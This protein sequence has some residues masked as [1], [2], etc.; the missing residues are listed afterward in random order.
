MTENLARS[1]G[2]AD[3]GVASR[4]WRRPVARNDPSVTLQDALLARGRGNSLN[5]I[6]LVLASIVIGAHAWPLSGSGATAAW[7][8]PFAWQAV[9]G[10][11]CL[12]GFLIARSRMTL[13]LGR[14]MWHRCLRILPAYYVVLVVIAFVAA[15]LSTV[16]GGVWRA[17]E[18]FTYV[19]GNGAVR[20]LVWNIPSTVDAM[21]WDGSLW[22]LF[23]ELLA[24]VC[25]G[26]L[27]AVPLARRH[28]R[29]VT[30]LL[31][32]CCAVGVWWRVEPGALNT[33]LFLETMRLGTYFLAGM[34]FYFWAERIRLDWRL[35]VVALGLVA[36]A[37]AVGRPDVLGPLPL[38]YFLL[39]LGATVPARWAQRNDVSY[40][41]YIYAFPVAVLVE[42]F[43]P[44]LSVAQHVGL[45]VL[46]TV[47]LAWASWLIVERPA[48]RHKNARWRRR[49]TP[50][51]Q[52]MAR[53]PRASAA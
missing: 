11:F 43:M 39:W 48:M 18:A 14:F 13:G 50:P 46:F 23:Y 19:V 38:A 33:S 31:L 20:Q 51:E 27:L 53:D 34:V 10:F 3:P 21:A 35:A 52:V 32:V 37:W 29:T 49:E 42:W 25:A 45:V 44:G 4:T 36:A 12:S 2:P 22:T 17:D 5:L 30:P 7:F 8:E 24:Y 28:A 41:V 26:L 1:T 15:P 6:R 47:P 40:G 16:G 9:P